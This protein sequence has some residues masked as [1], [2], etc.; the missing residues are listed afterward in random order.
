MFT[1]PL[2]WRG[3]AA[4]VAA[5]VVLVLAVLFAAKVVG[6][7]EQRAANRAEA[8]M[9]EAKARGL[10]ATGSAVLSDAQTKAQAADA[11]Q[12]QNTDA[13][14]D[15]ARRDPAA[16]IPLPPS[17]RDRVRAGDERLRGSAPLR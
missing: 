5:A 13:L 4:I 10:E 12:R 17:V 14:N 16:Q 15:Q 6:W 9:D 8:A 1:F 3:V 11:A 2:T 7:V